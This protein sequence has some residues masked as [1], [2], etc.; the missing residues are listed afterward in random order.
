LTLPVALLAI[1]LEPDTWLGRLV[2]RR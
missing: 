1:R 2:L